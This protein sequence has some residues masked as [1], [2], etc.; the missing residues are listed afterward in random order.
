MILSGDGLNSVILALRAEAN[1]KPG[2]SASVLSEGVGYHLV[3]A[4]HAA[5]KFHK[6]VAID[7]VKRI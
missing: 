7:K 5:A 1:T 6:T 2:S 3:L 4:A